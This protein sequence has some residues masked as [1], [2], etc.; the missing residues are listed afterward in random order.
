MSEQSTTAVAGLPAVGSGG[1][2]PYIAPWS[3]ERPPPEVVIER[4]GRGI[5]FV[6]ETPL[7]RDRH[8][9]LWTRTLVLPGQ[10][11]PEFQKV[12]PLRQRRAMARLLCQVC[13]QPADVDERGVLWLLLDHRDD[14]VGWPEKMANTYPPLCLPCAR[15]AVRLCPA[16]RRGYVA[17]RAQSRICGVSGVVYRAG[18]PY[19]RTVSDAVV[20]Y[21]DPAIRWTVAAQLVRSLHDCTVIDFDRVESMI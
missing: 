11:R 5:G 13:A 10:G 19:P 6:D 14:W 7:D 8:G 20:A 15:I 12:H 18:Y 3:G 9:V 17:V 16:L 4:A 2:V 1:V 21:D